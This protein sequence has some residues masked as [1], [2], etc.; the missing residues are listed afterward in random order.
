MTALRGLVYLPAAR[1]RGPTRAWVIITIDDWNETFR[2]FVGIPLQDPRPKE[3]LLAP[4]LV[5]NGTSVDAVVGRLTILFPD[6][7][8]GAQARLSLTDMTRVERALRDLLGF[9]TLFSPGPARPPTPPGPIAYPLW[10]DMHHVGPRIGGEYK[11]FV[12]VSVNEWN[13]ADNSALFV[14]TTSKPKRPTV[15]FPHIEN[16]RAQA[17]CGDVTFFPSSAV[18]FHNRP[19]SP[20]VST[21]DMIAIAR[22]LEAVLGL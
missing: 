5:T 20:M 22:G 1:V 16:G 6:D 10:G 8:S 7:L 19:P 9:P 13:R 2:S 17:A 18:H 15:Y 12:V 11:R 21:T 4:R 3:T 14:R